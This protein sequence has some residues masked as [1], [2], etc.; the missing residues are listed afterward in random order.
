LN[1]PK[2]TDVVTTGRWAGLR[3][4]AAREVGQEEIRRMGKIKKHESDT[5]D[6]LSGRTH[7]EQPL[8]NLRRLAA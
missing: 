1:K 5:E 2:I 4:D 3:L 6:F 7:S 8:K